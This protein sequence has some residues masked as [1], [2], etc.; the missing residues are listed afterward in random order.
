M[1]LRV[2]VVATVVA[3]GVVAGPATAQQPVPTVTVNASP[4]AATVGAAGPIPS[5]PTRLNFVRPAGVT[6]DISAYVALLV[7]GVSLEQIQ[8][9][10]ASDDRSEGESTLGLISI[11]ASVAVASGE[12]QRAVTF[13]V[14]PGLTY[15]VLVEQD[16]ERG[17]PPRSF[18]TFSSSGAA[19]GAVAPAPAA[20]VRMQG[21]RFKGPSSLKQTGTVRFENRDGV[22]HF[23]LAFPLRKG[24]T[25][26]QLGKAVRGSQRAFGRIVAGA[27]YMAQSVISGGDT[28]NDQEVHFPKKGRYGLVCFIGQHER[29]G[30]YRLITVK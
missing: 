9:T 28:Y 19:N 18:T 12:A 14:K 16:T 5:G 29:L 25:T 6:K 26:A 23:A 30:M 4:T 13:N 27:P 3:L 8:L 21:L 11:Q 15:V 24:T 10:L 2:T 17:A 20:T 22:A 7:P 1:S